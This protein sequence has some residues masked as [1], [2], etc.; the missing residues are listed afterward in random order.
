MKLNNFSAANRKYST[1]DLIA[2]THDVSRVRAHLF[3]VPLHELPQ[4][5]ER[6]AT[7][8]ERKLQALQSNEVFVTMTT[9]KVASASLQSTVTKLTGTVATNE[10]AIATQK[11]EIA[12]LKGTVATQKT[13]IDDLKG[14]VATQKTEI[15]DLKNMLT[16]LTAKFDAL[17]S[18]F[19]DQESTTTDLKSTVAKILC[20]PSTS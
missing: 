5:A 6:R 9:F 19:D 3:G 8:A 10:T 17:S 16:T 20:C 4:A 14:T 2:T 18:K 11:T 15:D 13:E 1:V 12:D 7:T